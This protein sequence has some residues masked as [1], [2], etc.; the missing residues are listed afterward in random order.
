VSPTPSITVVVP[1]YNEQG[2]LDYLLNQLAAQTQQPHEVILVNSG[3]TDGSSALIDEWISKHQK[4]AVFKNLNASTKTPG[5][6]KSAG[7][8]VANGELLAFMDCGLNFPTDWLQSQIELLES[9]GADW[10]SGVC[11]TSGTTVVDKA[12]I[13]H[14]YGFENARPVI[15]SS[16]VRRSVFDRIGVFKDLRAGYDAEWAQASRRAGL[17]REV[18]RHLIVEYQG[19]NFAKDLRGVFLKSLRYA[20]PSVGRNDTVVPYVYVMGG[21]LAPAI[22]LVAP[23]FLPYAAALYTSV[24]LAIAWRKSK[25]LGY[26]LVSPTRLLTLVLVGALMDFGKIFGFSFGI[27]VRHIRRQVLI[28]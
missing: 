12:A 11:R 21:L 16:V 19:V 2:S 28:A 6:S 17:R 14:T 26:F 20:R 24:R 8:N 7:I 25:G 4:Q 27:F 5:G 1:Y 15:P 22:A 13:A 9:T 10:V 3:S 18:N 23:A